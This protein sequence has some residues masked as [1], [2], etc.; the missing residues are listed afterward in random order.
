MIVRMNGEATSVRDCRGASLLAMTGGIDRWGA[1]ALGAITR[2]GW[3]SL[4]FRHAT[5]SEPT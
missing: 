2:F 1:L 5:T 4:A 3:G